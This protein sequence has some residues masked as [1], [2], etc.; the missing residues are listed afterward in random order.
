MRKF[1]FALGLIAIFGLAACA[2]RRASTSGNANATAPSTGATS[3]PASC[4]GSGK[5]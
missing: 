3:A 2:N 4:G 1:L 5:G